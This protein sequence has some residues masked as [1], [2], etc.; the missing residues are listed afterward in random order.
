[1]AETE[2]DSVGLLG[3]QAFVSLI[4]VFRKEASFSL[5]DLPRPSSSSEFRRAGSNNSC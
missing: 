2:Q 5:H 1:M 4:L 3:T